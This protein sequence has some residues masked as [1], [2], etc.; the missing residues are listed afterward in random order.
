MIALLLLPL[1]C[2]LDGG[3]PT[4][5]SSG[6]VASENPSVLVHYDLRQVI[7][8]LDDGD[9]WRQGLVPRVARRWERDDVVMPTD[10]YSAVP[11]EVVYDVIS[12]TLGDAMRERGRMMSL[13]GES[14]L[15]VLAPRS[16]QEEVQKILGTLGRALAGSDRIRL[17]VLSFSGAAGDGPLLEK[18][19]LS[20]EEADRMV[21]DLAAKGAALHTYRFDLTP[22]RTSGLTT[23]RDVSFLLD[24]DVE[25]AQA[26]TIY[27]P[28]VS[29]YRD[30]TRFLMRAT[31]RGASTALSILMRETLPAE[32]PRERPLSFYAGLGSQ[33]GGGYSFHQGPDSVQIPNI[34][35]RGVAFTTLIPDGGVVA[36]ASAFTRGGETRREVCLLRR[37]GGVS[38]PFY[39]AKF[40]SVTLFL[41]N[42]ELFSPPGLSF[43]LYTNEEELGGHPLLYAKLDAAPATFLFDWLKYRFSVWRRIGPWAVV[44]TDPAWDNQALAD[45][46]QLL[47][48]LEEG[49]RNVTCSSDLQAP[50]QSSFA[51]LVLPVLG[52]T[53]FGAVLGR[54]TTALTDFDV[55]VAQFAGSPD[56]VIAP[57]FDG[58]VL[59]GQAF[60]GPK[61]VIDVSGWGIRLVL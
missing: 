32:K 36:F 8:E 23:G 40:G 45:L 30:G 21:A 28:V 2:G 6:A 57:L 37:E 48:S 47:A 39:R 29:S 12:R 51:R 49:G 11:S 26:A 13:E 20:E 52:G 53:G 14:D 16:V 38:S 7:P 3:S 1:L 19:A 55:E 27:D 34:F 10:F 50:D 41:V 24:Y 43:D 9:L 61:P 42:S 5:P 46:E 22:G 56:P 31:R 17:E 18:T 58:M 44:V 54:T 4:A 59:R 25:I 15:L 35:S 60:S 33:K